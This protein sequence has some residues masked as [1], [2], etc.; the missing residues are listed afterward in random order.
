MKQKFSANLKESRV[1]EHSKDS[2][3]SDCAVAN[4]CRVKKNNI[5]LLNLFS[6]MFMLSE[7]HIIK[8]DVTTSSIS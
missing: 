8:T 1:Y 3:Y 2:F 5:F 4:Y 7:L 6:I